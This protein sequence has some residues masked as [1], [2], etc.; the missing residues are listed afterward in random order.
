MT[1][2][3]VEVRSLVR[4]RC[5]A[6]WIEARLTPTGGD[7]PLE[8]GESLFGILKFFKRLQSFEI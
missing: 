6:P 7:L 8:L 5:L 4:R 3:E 1:D 2:S